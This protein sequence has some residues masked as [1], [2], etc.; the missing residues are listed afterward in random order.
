MPQQ[1]DPGVAAGSA[2]IAQGFVCFVRN[3]DRCQVAPAQRPSQI[4]G[5]A[6]VSLDPLAGLLWDQ[7][8]G[9]HHTRRAK[10]S[11]MSVQAIATRT[12]LV[13]ER[14]PRCWSQPLDKLNHCIGGI[15]DHA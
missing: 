6:T 9:H 7:A 1:I 8:R 11:Q 14:Q 3:P 15:G 10:A 5:I 2:E 4:E 13:A 12:R